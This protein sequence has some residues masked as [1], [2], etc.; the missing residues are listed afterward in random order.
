MVNPAV[1]NVGL[2]AGAVTFVPAAPG[3]GRMIPML[4]FTRLNLSSMQVSSNAGSKLP[5]LALTGHLLCCSQ[6]LLCSSQLL[7]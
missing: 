7:T 1:N 5:T 3:L 2:P 6:P 4:R